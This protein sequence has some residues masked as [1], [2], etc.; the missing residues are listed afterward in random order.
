MSTF[1]RTLGFVGRYKGRTL[2]AVFLGF[3]TIGANIGLMGTS[4][5]LIAKAALQPESVLLLWVPIVGVRF[6]GLSRGV[7]RYVER[8][9]S[10]D[11]TFRVLAYLR[12]WIYAR[13]E[14]RGTTLLEN[15]RS[16]DVLSAVVSDVNELQNLYLRVIAPPAVAVLSGMLGIGIVAAYDLRFGVILAVML[17]LAGVGIPLVSHRAG[18]RRGEAMVKHRAELYADAADLIMGMPELLV[19]GRAEETAERLEKVQDKLSDIQK[20]QNAA[21]AVTS[22]LM[23]ACTQLAM[24]LMLLAGIPLVAANTL[25]GISLPVLAMVALASFEAVSPLP[26]TFQQFG[27]IM[28]AAARLF[29]LADEEGEAAQSGTYPAVESVA[30]D[31]GESSSSSGVDMQGISIHMDNV[32]FRYGDDEPD[33][34]AGVTLE[35]RPGT[36]TAVVGESG[37][38]KSSMLQVLLKLRPYQTGT[39]KLDG[40]SLQD[41]SG[42]EA[43]DLFAVVSQNVQLFN[44]TVRDN[45]LLGKP[46]ATDEDMERAARQALIH[47]TI[48]RLPQGYDTLIGEWGAM[49]SGGERQRL[50]LARA[51][52]RDAPVLLFDE[53][54]GGLDSLTEA[55]FMRSAEAAF[56]GKTVMWI[57]HKLKGLEQMDEILVLRHGRITERGTHAELLQLKGDYW[58]LLQLQQQEAVWDQEEAV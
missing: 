6:F 45:L 12:S 46:G 27:S 36:R 20:G 31:R 3:L 58:S 52:L 10:H 51:L 30:A 1:R 54:T 38:G 40:R 22:G 53:P 2:L 14:P 47:D 17:V 19:Y 56:Q 55:A 4:G 21:A 41:I 16:G 11:V 32:V 26:Q 34:L 39:V 29:K 43:R 35:L 57:T 49:L 44:E 18:R 50:A 7:F 42:E 13:I 48:M 23:V 8:L 37:A 9:V 5:Y 25:S 24:W 28:A 33:A 15:R